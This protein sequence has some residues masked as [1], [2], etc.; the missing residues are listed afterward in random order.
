VTNYDPP[1]R[2]GRL[3]FYQPVLVERLDH[4]G[5]TFALTR[6][7]G[8]GGFAFVSLEPIGKD[9][10]V[11]ATLSLA[12]DVVVGEGRVAWESRASDG[13]Y[14]VGVEF[15]R[16]DPVHTALFQTIFETAERRSRPQ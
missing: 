2:F 8:Q 3:P 15:T 12:R 6:D 1:R 9:R 10:P 5:G 7:V 13:R 11:R 16:M 4:P 14:E